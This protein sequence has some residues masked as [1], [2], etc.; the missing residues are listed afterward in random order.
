MVP[1]DVFY[2]V[3]TKLQIVIT[4]VDIQVLI[5]RWNPQALRYNSINY[6][7]FLRKLF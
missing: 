1:L 7:D 3:F 5:K 2:L 6:V 4:N